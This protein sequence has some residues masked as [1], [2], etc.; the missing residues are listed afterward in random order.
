MLFHKVPCRSYK[1]FIF[2]PFIIAAAFF[3]RTECLQALG[4]S[5]PYVTFYP[6]V[7]FSAIYGGFLVGLLSTILSVFI[8][9]FLI[10]KPADPLVLTHTDWV[11]M[12]V[13]FLSCIMLSYVCE[14]MH[15]ALEQVH[16]RTAELVE[17]EKKLARL[18]RLHLVGQMAAS[19]GHEVR[20]PMT[21]V[22]GYLQMFQKNE[23]YSEHKYRFDLMIDELDRANSIITEFLSLS[24]NKAIS[25]KIDNLN[26]VIT[27]VF[28]L[29]QADALQNG[30]NIHFE[31]G[32]IP[33][34]FF[35]KKEMCQLVLNLV[36]NSVEATPIGGTIT[37]KTNVVDG[38]V[39]LSVH[40]TGHGIPIE[41]LDQ[42]GT[43]FVTTKETGTGL[44]L[45]ICY[46]IAERNKA[47][48]DVKTSTKGTDFYICFS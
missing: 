24:N 31:S 3:M 36:R 20:N 22:R 32:D 14:T 16:Q 45:S 1:R 23:K 48:I 34:I 10:I 33:D 26:A 5:L 25:L 18:D 41:I 44:G 30:Q 47:T 37:I 12:A 19:I 35:D 28:P 9:V 2:I 43:P 11:G 17:S 8:I 4:A 39:V 42:I 15:R 40:D 38:K 29:I 21:T 6:A 13:F 46:K 7:M 27:N